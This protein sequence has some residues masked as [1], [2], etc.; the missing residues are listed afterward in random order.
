[1]K[2]EALVAP[3]YAELRPLKPETSSAFPVHRA[4]GDTLVAADSDDVL[5]HTMAVCA[6]Y[7]YGDLD[8]LATIMTRMGLEQNHCVYIGEYVDALLITTASYLVQSADGRTVILAYR[9]TPPTSLI[10]ILTDLDIEPAR[11]SLRSPSGIGEFDVHAGIYRNVRATRHAVVA[12][13]QRAIDG[14]SVRPD[15]KAMQHPLEALYITGHSL[16]GA[17]AGLLAA[18][19]E[20]DQQDYGEI[21]DRLKGVYTFGAPMFGSPEFAAACEQSDFLSERV[22]RYVYE[23][24]FAPQIPVRENGRYAHFGQELRHRR[25]HWRHNRRARGQTSSLLTVAA[26]PMSFAARTFPLTRH[27]PFPVSIYDHLP[28]NYIDALTPPGVQSEYGD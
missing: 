13:L 28:R 8:T 22:I 18:M 2:T 19:L 23:S 10:T 25:G 14:K 5:A 1:M 3:T 11:I 27:I 26:A 4:L 9:G 15:G 6:G 7:A 16:G 21:N 20:T 24:D 17:S 12:A